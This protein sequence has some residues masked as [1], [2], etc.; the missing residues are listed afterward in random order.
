MIRV[1]IAFVIGLLLGNIEVVQ[2]GPVV[3]PRI[4]TPVTIKVQPR[5]T[6]SSPSQRI[7]VTYPVVHTSDWRDRTESDKKG[8]KHN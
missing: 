5:I 3:T 2:A 1:L 6:H 8:K 4:V 7:I